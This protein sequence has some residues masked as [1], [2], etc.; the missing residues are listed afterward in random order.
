MVQQ[1]QFQ[2]EMEG[3]KQGLFDGKLAR[4]LAETAKQKPS[5]HADMISGAAKYLKLSPSDHSV[6]QELEK[7][8]KQGDWKT[9]VKAEAKQ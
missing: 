2:N 3:F 9:I 5:R 6:R 1:K 4:A 8:Y 7:A